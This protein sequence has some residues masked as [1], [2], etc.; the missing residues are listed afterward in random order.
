MK[1]L[2]I[3]NG[4]GFG[5]AETWLLEIV[6]QNKNQYCFDFLLTGGVEK[7]LD[8]EFKREGCKLYYVKFSGKRMLFFARQ[9]NKI[10]KREAYDVIHDHEDFVAGW[11]WL[12]LLFRLPRVRISHAHNSMIYINNYSNSLGRK[13]FY[14][15]GK[16]L[17]GMLTTSLT[18]TSNQLLNELGYDRPFYRSKR[19][20]PL[21][22]GIKAS[23]FKFNQVARDKIRNE[24]NIAVNDKVVIFIGR[25]GLSRQNEINHKNPEFAFEIAKCLTVDGSSYKVLFVGEK[26]ALGAALE[27][28]AAA[29]GLAD[30]IY[31]LGKRNDVNNVLSASDL[32]LFTS[33]LE[34]FGL[35]LVEAQFN[36]LPVVGSNII[37][38]EL[39]LFPDMFMLLDIKNSRAPNWAN[40]IKMYFRQP[41]DRLA[42]TVKHDRD[43]DASPFTIDSSYNRLLKYYV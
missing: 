5:G 22:C 36:S 11:H 41:I 6:K 43:I 9:L 8:I 20:E 32:M 25:I 10:V 15:L 3:L 33:T 38:K 17:T 28:Q 40:Q 18:G 12:F 42:Y 19:I 4:F 34:P 39:I 24:F 13:L 21:Y 16:W 23:A 26:G 30:R 27:K 29:L 31:F 14:R 35:V 2:H 1:V 37:T 7:E